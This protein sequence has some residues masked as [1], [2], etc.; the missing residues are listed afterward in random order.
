MKRGDLVESRVTVKTA[1]YNLSP[2]D[3]CRVSE[4]NG[5]N[6]CVEPFHMFGSF[7]VL[8]IEAVTETTLSSDFLDLDDEERARIGGLGNIYNEPEQIVESIENLKDTK[9][10]ERED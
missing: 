5:K 8:P 2:G 4:V 1:D 3:V 9:E 6:I 7:L 10:Y